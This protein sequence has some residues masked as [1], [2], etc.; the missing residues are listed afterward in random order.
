[1]CLAMFQKLK[2][3]RQTKQT[4]SAPSG[5]YV[6]RVEASNR[7]EVVEGNEMAQFV[8]LLKVK[9]NRVF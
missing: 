9:T 8:S 6:V 1:M 4:R 5:A 3:Q 7:V 2:I